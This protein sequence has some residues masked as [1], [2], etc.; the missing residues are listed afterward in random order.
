MKEIRERKHCIYRET[1]IRITVN[2]LA[3]M[4]ARSKIFKMLKEE[5]FVGGAETCNRLAPKPY[6]AVEHWEG[7]LSYGGPPRGVRD[8]STTLGLPS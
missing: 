8:P 6:V 2:L 5:N 7:Y 3:S 1:S 4:E